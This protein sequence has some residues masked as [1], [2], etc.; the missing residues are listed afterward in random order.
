MATD[1]LLVTA[2]SVFTK[3]ITLARPDI[4]WLTP[5][6][7]ARRVVRVFNT[8]FHLAI[9]FREGILLGG[10]VRQQ[11]SSFSE[12]FAK[13]ARCGLNDVSCDLS[14]TFSEKITEA[15]PDRHRAGKGGLSRSK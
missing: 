9:Y 11:S 4:R 5:E 3:M 2:V 13:A 1:I 10:V 6:R 14:C 8:H 7:G 12:K 15:A